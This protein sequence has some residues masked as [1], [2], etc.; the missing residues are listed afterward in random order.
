MAYTRTAES[1][2]PPQFRVGT[3][4]Q[5]RLGSHVVRGKVTEYRGPLASGRQHLY[6]V[7]V[8]LYANDIQIYELPEEELEAA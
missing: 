5:F 7:E 6:R 3:D 8:P 1:L 4:V 2:P